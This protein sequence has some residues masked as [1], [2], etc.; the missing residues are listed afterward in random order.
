MMW[1]GAE[2]GGKCGKL[3]LTESD[4]GV[5][6]AWVIELVARQPP[7]RDDPLVLVALLRLLL[8][9]PSISHHL[10][11]ELEELLVELRWRND[12]STRRQVETAITS[13]VRLLYDR[14]LDEGAERSTSATTGGGYYH[15]LTGH[16]RG[17]KS[18][19]TGRVPVGT[20]SGV[21][22]DIG[23]IKG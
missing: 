22:F 2:S 5:K 15:L 12:T 6:T 17:A 23:F 3:Y 13:Y 9:R 4:A 8:S 20:L 11:F 19:S 16:V 1:Y 14:Q 21:Y 10:E 7:F 18:G